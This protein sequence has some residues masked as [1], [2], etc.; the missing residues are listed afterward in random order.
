[1][2]AATSQTARQG[3]YLLTINSLGL[4]LPFL[5]VGVG[6][7]YVVPLLKRV[8]HYSKWIYVISGVLLIAVGIL[9]LTNK[10]NW[11]LGAL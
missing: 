6:F 7:D 2:Q 10:L 5:A 1:M 8:S 11:L 3:A 4:A 9:I